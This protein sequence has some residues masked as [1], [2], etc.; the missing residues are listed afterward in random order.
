MGHGRLTLRFARVLPETAEVTLAYAGRASEPFRARG[1]RVEERTQEVSGGPAEIA[2]RVAANESRGLGLRLDSLELLTADDSRVRL[3]G[4]ALWRP[5]AL[6]LLLFVLLR[7]FGWEASHATALAGP[8]AVA[9][10]GLLLEAPWLAHRLLTGLPESLAVLWLAGEVVAKLLAVPLADRRALSALLAY[11]FLL[12]AGATNHPD[13]YYPDLLTHARLAEAVGEAGPAFFLAP[14]ARLAEQGAWSKPAFGTRA[15]L[16][17]SPAFHLPFA[18][19]G[20]GQ[21]ATITAMKLYGAALSLLPIALVWAVAR[22]LGASSIGAALMLLIPTYASRLSFA[23]LP[24][25]FGHVFDLALLLFLLGPLER[26]AR[27]KGLVAGGLFVAGAELAYV[28]GVTHTALLVPLV[29]AFVLGLERDW[30]TAARLLAMGALGAALAFLLFYRDF[31]AS[32]LQV[33]AAGGGSGYP[34]RSFLALF[35]ERTWSF[36]RAFYPLLAVPGFVRLW[37]RGRGRP[38]LGAWLVAYLL[39]LLLR[40]RVPD[41]FRY[42]HETLFVT[43]LVCLAAGEV[44]QRIRGMGRF[45]R[46]A[47]AGLLAL[48]AAE[49]LWLQ[50]RAV[51]EQLGNAT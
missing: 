39:L 16:P 33:A 3:R 5:A 25:L 11:A 14:A 48:L 29:A 23:L 21:D 51:A 26:L 34:V 50:W 37:R 43:P 15:G 44:L 35:A 20:L 17:Y 31:V 32:A 19:F 18:L 8:I 13:F 46:L 42:G 7:R 49:G 4:L 9:L 2:L 24:A 28:S 40:A 10:A 38:V 45:G 1:G 41:V 36:F 30:R 6:A 27:P 12:R 22:R 47:A